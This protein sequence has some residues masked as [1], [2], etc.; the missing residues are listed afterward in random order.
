MI[1]IREAQKPYSSS[2]T[3]V[4]GDVL[5]LII[6]AQRNGD[7]FLEGLLHPLPV[8]DGVVAQDE[9]EARL[10]VGALAHD[11]LEGRDGVAVL[12]HA[13]EDQADVLHDLDP[14]LLVGVGHLVH[15]H[16]VHLD[17][18]GVVLLFDVDVAHVDFQAA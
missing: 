17:G 12:T 9:V 7:E 1:E 15:G 14:H 8:P 16:P 6:D 3:H 18:L 5:V 2:A 13:D 4:G 10:D 11:V